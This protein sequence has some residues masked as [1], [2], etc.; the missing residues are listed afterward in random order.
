M[1]KNL[2]SSLSLLWLAGQCGLS[3]HSAPTVDA[4]T[5]SDA[6]ASALYNPGRPDAHAPIGVMRDHTHRAGE[7]M[8]S[9]RYM[10]MDMG[11]Y[12]TGTDNLSSQDIFDRGFMVAPTG[13]EMQMHMFG[14]MYAP[15]DKLTLAAMINYQEK[16]MD[17]VTRP[18]SMA[19]MM[20]GESFTETINGWGD[21]SVS[22]LYKIYDANHQRV[23]LSLGLS[24]P[25][26]SLN[27]KAYPMQV[28]TGTWDL[29]PGVTWLWQS[30]RFSGGAQLSGRFHLDENEDG[31]AYGDTVEGTTWAAYEINQSFSF[32]GRVTAQYVSDIEGEDRDLIGR[33]MAPPM[34]AQNWGGTFSEF[35][36]GINFLMGEGFFQGNRLAVEYIVPIYQD[37]NGL[38]MR[39]EWTL[40]AGWQ[41]A[42]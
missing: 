40:V 20:R 29:L 3:G 19:R 38:Q 12:R 6:P 5:S 30:E 36:V 42:W 34:E 7:W 28:T 24:A 10:Y 4:E 27:E 16:T 17:H 1:N 32:S 22:G 23:H 25:T 33:R 21:L 8:A 39:R 9:Y 26:G 31:F 35:G 14:L 11:G 18:G 2:L 37:V 15:T 13:M 41:L